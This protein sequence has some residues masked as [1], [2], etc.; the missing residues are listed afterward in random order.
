MTCLMGSFSFLT[1]QKMCKIFMYCN[2]CSSPQ[3][4]GK[5]ALAPLRREGVRVLLLLS[6]M[7]SS[8]LK[9]SDRSTYNILRSALPLALSHR[10]Y[11]YCVHSVI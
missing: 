3:R 8:F 5:S 10:V 1:L 9:R 6:G 11:F 4:G 7:V 2:S